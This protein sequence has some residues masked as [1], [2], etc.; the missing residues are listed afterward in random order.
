MAEPFVPKAP[1]DA[2]AGDAL[3]VQRGQGAG[4]EIEKLDPRDPTLGRLLVQALAGIEEEEAKLPASAVQGG[5]GGGIPGVIDGGG[6]SGTS[7]TI[8]DG[9][10]A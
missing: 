3:L 10:G 5:G 9:G 6:A 7:G 1:V 4:Y 2:L 8:I